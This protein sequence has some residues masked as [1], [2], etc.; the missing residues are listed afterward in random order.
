MPP[1]KLIIR[2]IRS[3]TRRVINFGRTCAKACATLV[4]RTKVR[5]WQKVAF[6][7]TPSWDERNRIIAGFIPANSSVLDVG[8]GAQTLRQHLN[9][10]CQYQPC[11]VVKSSTD[12]IFCDFNA[13]VYPDIKDR[14]DY[15]VCSGLLEYIRNPRKFLPRISLLGRVVILS[16]NPLLPGGS[17]LA[18]LGNDLG[19]VNHF[20]KGELESLFDEM[21]LKWT[22]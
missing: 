5:Q 1:H 14:F 16:Y 10:G 3:A 12:V 4:V 7:G 18:R 20:T 17:K 6:A 22:I 15:V 9:P 13:G 2:K 21:G 8:C 19:W 11:D